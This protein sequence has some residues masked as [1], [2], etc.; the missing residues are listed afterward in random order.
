MLKSI[1]LSTFA[2]LLFSCTTAVSPT[3]TAAPATATPE[4]TATPTVV[5][6]TDTPTPTATVTETPTITPTTEP[7]QTPRPTKA[8]TPVVAR[9]PVE[10]QITIYGEN[11]A[12]PNSNIGPNGKQ[13]TDPGG[14]VY[15]DGMFH[16]AFTGWPATVDIMYS[17]S[18][19]GITWELVQ[20]DPIYEGDEVE[21]AEV[22]LLASSVI[23]LEDGTWVM[24]FYTWDEWSWPASK[25]S[26]G[27]ATAP[28]PVGPWTPLDEPILMPGGKGEWDELAVRAPSV[29]QTDEGFTMFYSGLRRDSA[30]IGRAFS[31]D[32]LTWTKHN[33][34]ETEAPYAESDPIFTGSG[35]DWDASHVYQPRV[36]RTDQGLVMVYTS[37]KQMGG[38]TL[39][40]EHG[41]AFSQNGSDWV[42]S[43]TELF[44]ARDV[45]SRGQN[46]WFT[47]LV[48][49]LDRFYLYVELGASNKTEIYVAEFDQTLFPTQE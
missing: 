32:G 2:L 12:V 39:F 22:A 41:L 4:P 1:W 18:A 43:A 33:D 31:A 26:I 23:V 6:P 21:Y 9:F 27:L 20:E 45:Q 35:A 10:G 48:Y 49:A 38:N 28:S 36:R 15:H 19:D 34:P 40:Q 25:G 47:E 29:V 24:Y 30:S 13:Y 44:K 5:P 37:T 17:T 7:T 46:I 42:R 16:N 8:P 11:P 3:P 14:V